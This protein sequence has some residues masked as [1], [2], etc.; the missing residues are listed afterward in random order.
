VRP[1]GAATHFTKAEYKN[2]NSFLFLQKALEYEIDRQIDVL[3]S[4]GRVIQETRLWDPAAGAT[5]SMRSKE[6]AHDYRYF[7]EPDLPPVVVDAARVEAIRRAMPE[8]PD[9]RRQRFVAAYQLSEYDAAQVTQSLALSEFFE[10]AVRAGAPAKAVCNWMTGA[11]ARALKE[12]G[13]EIAASP[14]S[15]QRL[16]GLVA[17]VE[18]G[19]IS[20]AIAKTVFE[21]MVATGQAADDIVRA[22]GLTQ[23]DDESQIVE[24]ARDVLSKN[25]DAVA[26]YRA[27]K[28]ATFGFL[29]GQVMKAAAGK[30][31]PKRVNEVLTRML[32]L[33]S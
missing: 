16:A 4:G 13:R 22:Q 23:I 11:L 20:G 26:Q 24:F 1:S 25:P 29:V 30:A 10:A 27:G 5:L 32:E 19:A 31:N 14:V 33:H 2:L 18:R 17:L 8:L 28:T 7:P 21:K 15:P 9:A 3:E 6:E 12:S